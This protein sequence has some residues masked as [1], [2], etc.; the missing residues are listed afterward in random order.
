[1]K[2]QL[3]RQV[4]RIELENA[5]PVDSCEDETYLQ[6]ISDLDTI[7][8][9]GENIFIEFRYPLSK[10]VLLRFQKEGGFTKRD[11][12]KRIGEGYKKIYEDEAE[13]SPDPGTYDNLYNRRRSEGRYGI[14]GH[15]L[16]DLVIESMRYNSN[17]KTVQLFIGS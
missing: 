6:G 3:D 8:I 13:A 14:W 10:E 17:T 4:Q 15:Y 9:T 11:L 5:V 16:E 7:I 2:I 1:M 12:L